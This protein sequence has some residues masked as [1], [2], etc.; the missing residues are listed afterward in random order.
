M[1]A[2]ALIT[3]A[4][5]GLG[6]LFARRFAADGKSVV[7]VARRKDRLEELAAELRQRHSIRAE[8]IAADLED[9]EAPALIFEE[10]RKRGLEIEFL[11][12]NA[13]F[14]TSGPF[15]SN[16]P[17]KES[18][19]LAVN[20]RALTMLTRLF[21]PSLIARKRGRILNVGSTAGFQPGPFM[22][23]YYATKAYVNS[24]SEALAWELRGTGVTVTLSC[25]GATNTE[26]SQVAEVEKSP[27]F[28][29]SK[30]AS[31][32]RVVD[33]AYRAMLQGR[34]RIVHG[35]NNKLTLLMSYLS[36]MAVALRVASFM[37]RKG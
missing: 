31:A 6:A 23:V 7:L 17:A 8:V 30:P 25:P 13:G 27:L 26:F 4:S 16:D 14:G 21:L 15:V 19:Q 33:Q 20:M 22:A 1:S 11:V 29:L 36:P 32:E 35:I 2:F 5:S 10:I 24:F 37:N 12:N 3:G 9:P 28:R 34:R 18:A